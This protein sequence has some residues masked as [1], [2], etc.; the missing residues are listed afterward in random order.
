MS[1]LRKVEKMLLLRITD[2][3]WTN[4][5]DNLEKLREGIGIQAY[6]QRDPLIEYKTEAYQL[7]EEMLDEIRNET[8][9][10]IFHMKVAKK[11]S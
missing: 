8:I 11:E 10:T 7:F 4:H 2:R 9:K 1:E 6:G 3:K 5:I